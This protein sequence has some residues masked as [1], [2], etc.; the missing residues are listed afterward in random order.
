MLKFLFGSS[1]KTTAAGYIGASLTAILPYLQDGK[2]DW[3][4]IAVAAALA[5]IGRAAKD[6]NATG[7]G[8]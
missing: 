7:A 3:R 2:I 4:A 6:A 8:S 5:A 1:I